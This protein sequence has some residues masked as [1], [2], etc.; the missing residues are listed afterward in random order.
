MSIETIARRYAAALADVVIKNGETEIVRNELGQFAVLMTENPQLAEV[1]RNPAV[2]FDNKKNVLESLIAKTRPTKTTANFLRV[3][4]RNHRLSD[5][6]VV[7]ERFN[8][9]LE[10]RAGLVTAE[11]TTAQ[12]L[13]AAQQTALQTRLQ[14]LTGK[15]VNLNFKID[16]EIIGGVVTRIGSTVYDGSVKNQLQKLKEQMIRS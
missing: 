8:A 6:P 15:R 14:Q 7:N 4:Q 1:F 2:A 16:P 3:L 12:P 10:V 9:V 13:A 5:L 11:V